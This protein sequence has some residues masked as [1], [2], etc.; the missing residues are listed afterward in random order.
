[1]KEFCISCIFFNNKGLG[2][3]LMKARKIT[4]NSKTKT[5]GISY[6][7]SRRYSSVVKSKKYLLF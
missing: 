3:L 1:M 6:M 7:S 2:K 5:V 4:S